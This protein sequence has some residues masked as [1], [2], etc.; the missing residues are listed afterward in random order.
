MLRLGLH[1]VSGVSRESTS[2]RSVSREGTSER[3]VSREGTSERGVSREGT[4]ERGVSREGT[5][6]RGGRSVVA[7]GA[8]YASVCVG[9]R[10]ICRSAQ[11]A[12]HARERSAEFFVTG[13]VASPTLTTTVLS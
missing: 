1:I 4:S 11:D 6:E 2:E 8:E 3:G 12:L 13:F 5:S 7:A 10:R 9:L